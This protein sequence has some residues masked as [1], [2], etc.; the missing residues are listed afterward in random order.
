MQSQ[1][2]RVISLCNSSNMASPNAV[3]LT[4]AANCRHKGTP[5]PPISPISSHSDTG[6]GETRRSP[7]Q[8]CRQQPGASVATVAP[9]VQGPGKSSLFSAA[10]AQGF[11]TTQGVPSLSFHCSSAVSGTYTS[12]V[13][14]ASKPLY[15]ALFMAPLRA[16]QPLMVSLV[17]TSHHQLWVRHLPGLGG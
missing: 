14:A 15:L 10:A 6:E 13:V 16:L 11:A 8:Q 4:W 3:A 12:A 7:H 5:L 1:Q 9:A 2:Y 17:Y